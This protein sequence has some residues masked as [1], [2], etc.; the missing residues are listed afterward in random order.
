MTEEKTKTPTKKIS[1]SE[2]PQLGI[3]FLKVKKAKNLES[4]DAIGKSDPYVV[5]NYGET[6]LVSAAKSN[7]NNPEWDFEVDFKVHEN[8][9]E[10]IQVEVMD[11]DRVGANDSLGSLTINTNSILTETS[12]KSFVKKLVVLCREREI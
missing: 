5:I 2:S 7:T 12:E 9:P 11:K 1:K 3:L 4:K 10:T 8:H 6:K